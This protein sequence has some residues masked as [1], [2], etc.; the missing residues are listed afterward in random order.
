V[1]HVDW[2]WTVGSARG[3]GVRGRI[4]LAPPWPS[5]LVLVAAK[6]RA[7]SVPID[8]TSFAMERAPLVHDKAVS[9]VMVGPGCG[10]RRCSGTNFLATIIAGSFG[11]GT[12]IG[13]DMKL[14]DSVA[15]VE[16]M[17]RVE[18]HSG[19]HTPNHPSFCACAYRTRWMV[20]GGGSK[21]DCRRS[22][23]A[24]VTRR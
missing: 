4:V 21:C 11:T 13:P 10:G 6:D 9:L 7:P 24:S 17:V 18:S 5:E 16:A 2:N 23:A 14:L 19:A 15:R 22:G 3:T 12:M 8:A 20:R 1:E